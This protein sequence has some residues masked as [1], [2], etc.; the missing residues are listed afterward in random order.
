MRELTLDALEQLYLLGMKGALTRQL[1]DPSWNKASFEERLSD[2]IAA[3]G[4]YR[5]N[6]LLEGRLRRARVSQNARIEEGRRFYCA[7]HQ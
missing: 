7:R 4:L 5:E 1:E 6:R 3:E 2:L